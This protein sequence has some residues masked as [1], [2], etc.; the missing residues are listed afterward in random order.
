MQDTS[1][2]LRNPILAVIG[3]R[4]TL[5]AMLCHW[6]QLCLHL[7]LWMY[8]PEASLQNQTSVQVVLFLATA[9]QHSVPGATAQSRD[10]LSFPHLLMKGVCTVYPSHP[11]GNL[12]Q[13]HQATFGPCRA[14]PAL[15]HLQCTWNMH[16]NYIRLQAKIEKGLVAI[17]LQ[18]QHAVYCS[19]V[20][21]N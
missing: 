7:L 13:K 18:T 17:T 2:T 12:L 21:C 3:D 19:A 9:S 5:A 1:R 4:H 8:T 16:E 6:V 14:V 10:N 11:G 20:C 15:L